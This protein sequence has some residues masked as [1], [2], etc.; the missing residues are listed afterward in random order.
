MLV[1]DGF[2][3]FLVLNSLNINP[4]LDYLQQEQTE[5]GWEFRKLL[6]QILNI[7]RNFGP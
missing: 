6:K 1:K 3:E 2:R 7:L 5:P 4:G